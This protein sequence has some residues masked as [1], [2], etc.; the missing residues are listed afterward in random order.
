MQPLVSQTPLVL[1]KQK[2]LE[3]EQQLE[4]QDKLNAESVST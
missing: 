1:L 3:E 4:L 2:M